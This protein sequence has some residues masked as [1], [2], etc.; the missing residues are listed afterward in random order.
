MSQPASATMATTNKPPTHG[1]LR[2]DQPRDLSDLIGAARL[3]IAEGKR[4][5]TGLIRPTIF[6]GRRVTTSLSRLALRGAGPNGDGLRTPR[7]GIRFDLEKQQR[8]VR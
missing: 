7:P 1:M 6:T 2:H 3:M 5:G 4:V 8:A